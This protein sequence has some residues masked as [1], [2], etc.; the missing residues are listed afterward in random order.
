MYDAFIPYVTKTG[1][2]YLIEFRT[3]SQKY[4]GVNIPV[5][6]VSLITNSNHEEIK[7][8]AG[9][10]LEI[11]T[12]MMQQANKVDAVYYCICSDAKINKSK[13][14]LH[15]SH[16]QYRSHLFSAM[17]N[18]LNSKDDYSSKEVVID[19]PEVNHHYIHVISLN[20]NQKELEAVESQLRNFD[21]PH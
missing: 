10:L 8:D 18:K 4:E 19:D 11:A 15:L 17:F 9:A 6:G 1:I 7:N 16:Q 14:R 13:K 2:Q 5:I 3:D 12:I 21:K 20:K